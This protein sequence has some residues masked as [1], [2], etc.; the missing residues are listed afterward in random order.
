[1]LSNGEV[2][3]AFRGKEKKKSK[4]KGQK[5]RDKRQNTGI[6]QILNDPHFPQGKIFALVSP[7]HWYAKTKFRN[8]GFINVH[9]KLM[10]TDRRYI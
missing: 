7:K 10:R 9:A 8:P 5:A 1:M 4:G 6:Q 3:V 2:K